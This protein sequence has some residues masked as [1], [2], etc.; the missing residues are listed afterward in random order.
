[1]AKPHTP[2]FVLFALKMA[3]LKRGATLH[4]CKQ[5]RQCPGRPQWW[6]LVVLY[7]ISQ[8]DGDAW[9]GIAIAIAML[10]ELGCPTGA[11]R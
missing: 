2:E 9:K 7:G 6:Q 5:M 4:P 8:P 1:M 11:E 10:D 3:A